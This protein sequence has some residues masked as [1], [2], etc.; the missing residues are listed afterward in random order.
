MS[1]YGK[2]KN[3]NWFATTTIGMNELAKNTDFEL[4][5]SDFRLLFYLLSKIDDDNRSKVPK[6]EIISNE[7]GLSVRKI[8]EALRKL[9][10]AKIIIKTK[11]QARTYFINPTFFYTGG[12]KVIQEKQDDFNELSETH[13]Y[14]AYTPISNDESFGI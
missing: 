1:R 6:Q 4:T 11:D 12:F 13:G 5:T 10:N 14:K 3:I 7:I 8:S 9:Q 2:T